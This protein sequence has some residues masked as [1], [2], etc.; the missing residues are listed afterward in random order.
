L[1]VVVTRWT[2]LGWLQTILWRLH[3][4][5][6]FFLGAIGAAEYLSPWRAA[7]R[8]AAV[9]LAAIL[10]GQF[11]WD[12]ARQFRRSAGLRAALRARFLELALTAA[13]FAL[14]ASQVFVWAQFLP[15]PAARQALE[16]VYRQYAATFLV[17]AG[18]RL[19][20]GEFPVRRL[21]HR[22]EL[23]PAQTVAMGFAFA[24]L[25]GTLLLSLPPAVTSLEAVSMLNALFTAT[26]SV[27]VTGLI[28]YDIGTFH[29]PLGQ[30]IILCLIQLGGLGTMAASASL[31]ILAGRRL[32]LRT[33]AALQESMDL[34]TVG[35][36]TGQIRT[37]ILT[38]L[39]AEG[40][41]TV[42]LFLGWREHP[43]VGSALFAA[44]F[45]AVS[46]FCNAGFSIFSENLLPLRDHLPTNA[47]VG[48]LI[49]LGGLGFPVI[50]GLQQMA[51]QWIHGR[52]VVV[53]LHTRLALL[54]TGLLLAAGTA[55]VLLVEAQGVLAGLPWFSQFVS[56]LFQSITARTAGFNTLDVGAMRPAT[57]WLLMLLMFVGGCPGSTAG[58]I[59]TT[60]AAAMVAT[61]WATLTGRDRVEAFRR[62]IPAEQVAKA[63]AVVGVSAAT[64]AAVTL[65]LLS[66]ESGSPLALTFEAVSAFGTVG[67]SVG[68]TSGLSQ[69]GK[70][71][72]AG[73]MF[74]GRT[75]PLTLG[76]ALAVRER[77]SRVAYPAEKIMIG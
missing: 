30:A 4:R 28:V 61:F 60:T 19:L 66:T 24:I 29:T 42:L 8:F 48:G 51:S 18:L 10:T 39:A 31:V 11:L 6:L 17:V 72:I 34:Q 12:S 55:V 1:R 41:G 62:T 27:T 2:A 50:H 52:R 54:S 49:V 7:G 3:W 43:A 21:L 71:F 76:F 26:S 22:L 47:T 25:A 13:A 16:P 33:A 56:A 37:I 58:G 44:V 9:V 53:S 14:L 38:T 32:R 77:R 59:K 65:G 40:V 70:L 20:V 74:V 73:A 64:V 5:P 36:V 75:G 46:A 63:L 45:H 69:W 23:R 57:L 68:V 35:Q 67:L 15:D